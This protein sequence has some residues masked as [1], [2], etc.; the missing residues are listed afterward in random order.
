MAVTG[1][2]FLIVNDI[3]TDASYQLIEPVVNQV[4]PVAGIGLGLQTVVVWDDGMYVGA[5]LLIG[6]RG[7]NLEVITITGVTPR[8]SFA[9]IFVNAHVAGEP[10]IGATFPCQTTAGDPFFLQSERLEYLATAINDFLIACPLVYAITTAI[11]FGSTQPIQ[12]LPADCQVPVRVAAFQ[13]ALRETSQSNLDSIDWRW[14]QFAASEP[15]AYYRDK[16]G[17]QNFGIWPVAN[18][19]TAIE[20]IYLQRSPQV[21]GMADGFLIPDPFMIYVKAR[22]FS[23]A[24]SKD[25]EARSPALAKYFAQRYEMGVKITNMFLEVVNDPSMQ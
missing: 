23:F 16:T 9:A 4:V 6:V 3:L 8:T 7:G 25:G 10:I 11:S 15:I 24:Y 2:G 20:M 14:Q 21:L 12:P 19:T 18:N 1:A 5:K 17:L 13:S 22:L